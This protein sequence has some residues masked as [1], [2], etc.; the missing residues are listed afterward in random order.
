M[1]QFSGKCFE[2]DHCSWKDYPVLFSCLSGK[3]AVFT[4][5]MWTET[6]KSGRKVFDSVVESRAALSIKLTRGPPRPIVVITWKEIRI[7]SYVLMFGARSL[8]VLP[9]VNMALIE[10]AFV[11]SDVW[12]L[13]KETAIWVYLAES[14]RAFVYFTD[15]YWNVWIW[16]NFAKIVKMLSMRV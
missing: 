7:Y 4:N 9:W 10:T 5:F 1:W 3:C 13:T 15:F 6:G 14:L 8:G 16:R 11:D 2:L 12:N